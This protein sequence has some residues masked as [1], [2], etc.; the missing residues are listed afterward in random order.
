[1]DKEGISRYDGQ[2]VRMGVK[3]VTPLAM[4]VVH[5][6]RVYTVGIRLAD[7]DVGYSVCLTERDPKTI[8]AMAVANGESK[9]FDKKML[10]ALE[11][12][13]EVLEL[14]LPV[15]VRNIN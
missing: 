2:V 10:R 13:L 14:R 3:D 4:G 5:G 9:R 12:G 8:V 6:G 15:V 1:M 11:D 7:N